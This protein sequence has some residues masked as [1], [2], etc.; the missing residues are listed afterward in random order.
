MYRCSM[1][2]HL[3]RLVWAGIEVCKAGCVLYTN[4]SIKYPH[5]YLRTLSLKHQL[6]NSSAFSRTVQQKLQ[7]AVLV[8]ARGELEN[9]GK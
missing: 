3:I 1:R 8:D 9:K 5:C 7:M 4:I 6:A 2:H